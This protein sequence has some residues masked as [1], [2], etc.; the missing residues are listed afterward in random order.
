MPGSDTILD[1]KAKL[2]A[3]EGGEESYVRCGRN[4]SSHPFS[5]SDIRH[6]MIFIVMLDAIFTMG[7]SDHFTF[8]LI[9][10]YAAGALGP[11]LIG[12]AC[13][14]TGYRI[15]FAALAVLGIIMLPVSRRL[16]KDLSADARNYQ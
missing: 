7:A 5:A 3:D 2:I 13:D 12:L 9:L 6:N 11:I 10:N 14:M 8:Q 4:P 15:T 1:D 16:L